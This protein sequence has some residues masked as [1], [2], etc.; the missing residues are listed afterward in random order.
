VN[1]LK[2]FVFNIGAEVHVI[3]LLD[4]ADV[5]SAMGES[6]GLILPFIEKCEFRCPF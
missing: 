3:E 2:L 4:I 6:R 1:L 5:L